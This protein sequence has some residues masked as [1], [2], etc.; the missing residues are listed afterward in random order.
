[1]LPG[2][3]FVFFK[4]GECGE[5]GGTMMIA[6][7]E[8]LVATLNIKLLGNYSVMLYLCWDSCLCG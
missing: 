6:E 8:K 3:L 7:D 2:G 5:E 4:K 1:M